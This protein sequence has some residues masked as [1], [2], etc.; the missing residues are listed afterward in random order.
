MLLTGGLEP[1]SINVN[2]HHEAKGI[3]V[4]NDVW[5][6]ANAI[7]LP[8]VVLEEGCVVA[9]GSVVTKNV[10]AHTIVG[11]NPAKPIREIDKSLK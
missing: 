6:G 11:G 5:I 4:E 8:G 3:I 1:D 7:I 10:P 2:Y 9:A